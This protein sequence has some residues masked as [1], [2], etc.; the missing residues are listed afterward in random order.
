MNYVSILSAWVCTMSYHETSGKLGISTPYYELR[1]AS[2]SEMDAEFADYK[3]MGV[4]WIRTD[5]WWNLIQPKASG[6]FNW[7]A[8][9]NVVAMAEKYGI[10]LIVELN[11]RPNWVEAGFT[12]ATSQQAYGAFAKAVAEHFGDRIDYWE[13]FN[14][15][16][17]GKITPQNY[18]KMLQA[19][20]T[21]I[22]SVDATDV[23]ISGGLAPA[24]A[25]VSTAVS[26][27]NYAGT[28]WGA[29][30][31]LKAMYTAGAAGYMDAVG[32]HPYT[33]PL[34]PADAAAW[35]GWNIMMRGIHST[36]VANGDDD[37]QI[38]ITEFGAPTSGGTAALSQADQALILKQAT[39]LAADVSWIGPILWYSYQDRGALGTVTTTEDWF[40]LVGPNG[41]RK[42]AY[43]AYVEIAL[44]QGTE[45]TFLG[46]HHTGTAANELI[47]GNSANNLIFGGRG[48]D[49]IVGGKGDDV[50]VGQWGND[51]LWGG[52]GADRF[53]F[54]DFKFMGWDIIKDFA[55][56][57]TIDLRNIDADL[58]VDGNQSFNFIGSKYL[59]KAGDL[60]FYQ[61]KG[62]WTTI[63]G[64]VTGDGKY[65]FGIRVDGRHTFTLDDFLL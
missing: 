46:L 28:I 29:V 6:G 41:E 53:V 31:Y 33:Y 56:G 62:G 54:N 47:V 8:V 50:L 49:I 18:T 14:E 63:A 16:N 22:K 20:Y 12:T 40:G 35:N 48:D 13:I 15:P 4:S 30:D 19:A 26:G 34:T 38:W 11:G 39:A 42:A 3:A 44:I 24:P 27:S 32:F 2:F 61:D 64:D 52:A 1:G 55:K 21:A 59:T 17:M 43:A 36:M 60:G 51:R 65:D 57:D 10:K 5:F 9:E 25:T 37:L 58:T 7:S 45:P 23:V